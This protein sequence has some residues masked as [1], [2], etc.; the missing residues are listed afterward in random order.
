VIAGN[1]GAGVYHDWPLERVLIDIK[2]IPDLAKIEYS[3]V[4]NNSIPDL[5]EMEYSKVW[6]MHTTT[7]VLLYDR[8][9]QRV[10]IDIKSIPDL[11]KIE[12]SKVCEVH[13]TYVV[14]LCDVHLLTAIT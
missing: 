5:D 8:P 2:S 7:S 14:P 11:T 12:Y 13:I 1:T 9:L 4:C 3:K 10:L 6:E